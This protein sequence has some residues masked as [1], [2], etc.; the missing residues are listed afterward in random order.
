M[1]PLRNG[2]NNLIK[3]ALT[4]TMG[5]IF[6]LGTG[7]TYSQDTGTDAA[8]AYAYIVWGSLTDGDSCVL[9]DNPKW[10]LG[11]YRVGAGEWETNPPSW[12]VGATETNAASLNLDL[13]RNTLNSSQIKYWLHFFDAPNGSLYVDLLNSNGVAIAT[14]TNLFGNLQHGSNVEAVVCMDIPLPKEAAV[15]QLRRGSGETRVYESLIS[16][17]ESGADNQGQ[18]KATYY[19]AKSGNEGAVG[20]AL[21]ALNAKAKGASGSSQAGNRKGLRSLAGTRKDTFGAVNLR[22][23][24]HLE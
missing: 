22:I 8:P 1:K 2:I 20:Q 18:A 6:I 3:L 13:D 16:L 5:A 19:Y 21:E 7:V 24:T 12:H 11:A 9:G 23:F 17:D 14:A 4:A 15:I 10:L